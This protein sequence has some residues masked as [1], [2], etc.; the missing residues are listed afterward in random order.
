[1]KKAALIF[2]VISIIFNGL[3]AQTNQEEPRTFRDKIYFGGNL[4]LQFGTYTHIEISPIVGYWITPRV[5][6]GFGISY[7]FYRVKLDSI[8][9]TSMYGGRLF[10]TVILIK[11]LNEFIGLPVNGGIIGHLEFESLSLESKYFAYM[12][13]SDKSRFFL[14]SVFVGGG[15]RQQFG[16][17]SSSYILVLWNLNETANSI[18]TSP[19]IRVGFTF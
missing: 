7:H 6:A 15:F 13:P 17:R 12:N 4:G 11:D 14:N 3:Y 1:M 2:C 18:Y 10:T 5:S 8:Y 19:V 9:N 16:E